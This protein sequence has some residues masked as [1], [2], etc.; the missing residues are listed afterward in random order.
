MRA[1][2]MLRAR[3]TAALAMCAA[4]ATAALSSLAHAGGI[5]A[6]NAFSKATAATTTKGL[7]ASHEHTYFACRTSRS[8]KWVS[9]CGAKPDALRVGTGELQYRFGASPSRVELKFPNDA[10]L[11]RDSIGYAHYFRAQVDRTELTFRQDNTDYTVFDYSEDGKRSA[12]VAVTLASG[13]SIEQRCAKPILSQ[14]G[15]LNGVVKCDVENA[16][17]AGQCKDPSK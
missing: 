1:V 13:K 3:L 5:G 15:E 17:N 2:A 12:G 6:A 10:R 7:C 16:L 4:I 8:K 9:V 11:G 14:L